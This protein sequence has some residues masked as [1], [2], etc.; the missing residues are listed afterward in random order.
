VVAAP[1]INSAPAEAGNVLDALDRR[2]PTAFIW[3]LTLLATLGGFLFGYDTANI[4]SALNFVP[5]H[6]GSFA[7]GYPVRRWVPPSVRSLPVRSPTGS[8][9]STCW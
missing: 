3:S 7:L 8:G 1:P 2:V 6:L 5:Y 4:G 9:E